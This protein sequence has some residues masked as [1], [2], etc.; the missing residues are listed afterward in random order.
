MNKLNIHNSKKHA[1]KLL[2]KKNSVS[3]FLEKLFMESNMSAK[4]AANT[5]KQTEQEYIKGIETPH[6]RIKI[7]YETIITNIDKLSDKHPKTNFLS[8]G[9]CLNAL[10]ILS[11]SLDMN[12]GKDLAKNLDD[13]YIYCAEKLREYLEDKDEQ[14]LFEV[15]GIIS[16]L[17]EAW[18]E[19]RD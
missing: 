13:L 5:Y 7:L 9:K 16:G 15:K 4:Q 1:Q 14:K 8:F 10:N 2:N 18:E 3:Y 12:K 17:L 6:G 19:I 11:S